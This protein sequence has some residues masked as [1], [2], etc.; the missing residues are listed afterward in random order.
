M[1]YRD[2]TAVADASRYLSLTAMTMN[3]VAICNPTNLSDIEKDWK[4][5]ARAGYF[6]N[7]DFRYNR[8]ELK[9]VALFGNNIHGY[10][11]QI[12]NNCV[13]QNKIDRVILQLLER[14][15]C[16]AMLAAEIAAGILQKEDLRTQS[17]IITAYGRP[18]SSF[19]LRCYNALENPTTYYSCNKPRFSEAKQA[20]L[21]ERS[22]KAS[23]IRDTFNAVLDYYG[24]RPAWECVLD[25]LV[26]TID[27][28]DKTEDGQSR[29]IVPNRRVVNARS[30]ATLIGHEI[31][32]HIR[33]SENSRA[34]LRR[35]L[36]GTPL[37]PLV[38]LL[39]KADNEQF[40]E[41]VA[42]MSDV[43]LMGNDAMP[44]PFFTIAINLAL[45]EG[46]SF[47]DVAKT[48]YMLKR[49]GAE[50]QDTAINFAWTVTRRVF[51]GATDT[52]KGF[53]FTK[54]YGYLAGY[55]VAR[56]IPAY[57]HDYSTFTLSELK[58]LEEAGVD[59]MS[60]AYPKKDAIKDVLGV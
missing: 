40:Y 21:E 29:L 8:E 59:L 57:L 2:R 20:E 56:N 50:K 33:G 44:H 3:P 53:A 41:G 15:T 10:W 55:D 13:C 24:F 18:S 34:L 17:A 26:K 9:R 27:A 11:L 49:T 47:G 43:A 23:E 58:F 5:S 37:E 1:I 14:R 38:N 51:R 35:I 6:P 7:P 4:A 42:K 25:P 32:C 30:M 28:R 45:N 52:S 19:I 31:E 36:G 54:D 22:F 48:V 12:R 39:A 46:K 16:D 60:P